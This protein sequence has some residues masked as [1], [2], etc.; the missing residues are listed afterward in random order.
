MHVRQPRPS[1]ISRVRCGY[2]HLYLPLLDRGPR[3]VRRRRVFALVSI[4]SEERKGECI[5]DIATNPSRVWV[6]FLMNPEFGLAYPL[7]APQRPS[8]VVCGWW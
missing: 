5:I 8:F 4:S 6:L 3:S 1:G 2:Q 7:V